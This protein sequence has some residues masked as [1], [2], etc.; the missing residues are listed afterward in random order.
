MIILIGTKISSIVCCCYF[1][2]VIV[3]IVACMII[4]SYTKYGIDR[5]DLLP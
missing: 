4:V 1:R 2:I 5:F 3:V